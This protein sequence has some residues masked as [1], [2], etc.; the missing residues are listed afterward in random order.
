MRKILKL[1][2]IAAFAA[3]AGY[4]IYSIQK[5]NDLS[6]LALANVEALAEGESGSTRYQTMGSCSMWGGI[7]Y[8]CTTNY[9]AERCRRDC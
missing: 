1:A 2:F 9:T 6:D 3:I 5:T 7:T 8:K 4:N